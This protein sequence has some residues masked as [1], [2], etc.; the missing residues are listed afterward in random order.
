M[1]RGYQQTPEH[2]REVVEHIREFQQK[3][4]DQLKAKAV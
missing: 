4:A 2:A 1:M 3:Y